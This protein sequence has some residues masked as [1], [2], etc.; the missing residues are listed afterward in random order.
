MGLRVSR[1]PQTQF[2]QGHGVV[3]GRV[4]RCDGESIVHCFKGR[5]QTILRHIFQSQPGI[6]LNA[7]TR[8]PT[9][10]ILP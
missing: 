4:I 3:C 5:C 7:L 9:G 1:F 8:I 10:L 6:Q 2:K